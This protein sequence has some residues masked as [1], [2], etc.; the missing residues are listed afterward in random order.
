VYRDECR[1]GVMMKGEGMV[2]QESLGREGR[3]SVRIVG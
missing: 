2:K 1:G 3:E